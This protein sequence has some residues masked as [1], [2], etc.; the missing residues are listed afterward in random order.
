MAIIQREA[1]VLRD[2]ELNK[3]VGFWLYDPNDA[4]RRCALCG[5]GIWSGR[6][7]DEEDAEYSTVCAR[8]EH[9]QIKLAHEHLDGF[10]VSAL[11]SKLDEMT[12][13]SE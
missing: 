12:W 11:Y 5:D 4:P 6:V 3:G 9:K 8:C 2:R 7:F 1:D 10:I 13:W